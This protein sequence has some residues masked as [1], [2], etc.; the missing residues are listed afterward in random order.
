MTSSS[1]SVSVFVS[2][3]RTALRLRMSR[4]L[5]LASIFLLPLPGQSQTYNDL[6]H[7]LYAAGY[8][9]SVWVNSFD[10]HQS[11]LAHGVF[12]PDVPLSTAGYEARFGMTITGSGTVTTDANGF[13]VGSGTAHNPNP[14]TSDGSVSIDLLSDG[15]LADSVKVPFNCG[16]LANCPW[17]ATFTTR[18]T[19]NHVWTVRVYRHV[20][21]SRCGGELNPDLNGACRAAL[22]SAFHLPAGYQ[23]TSTDLIDTNYASKPG[24]VTTA[25]C[26]AILPICNSVPV[27]TPTSSF[28]WIPPAVYVNTPVT[29]IDTSTGSPTGWNWSFSGGTPTAST[30]Q[31][32]VV[33]FSSAGAK[34]VTLTASNS[35]GRGTTA[36]HT[37][38]VL[39][40]T[41]TG[42]LSASA[43]SPL[44]CQA[45]TLTAGRCST[46]TASPSPGPST[47]AR[48]TPGR[49][50]RATPPASTR[51]RS[52]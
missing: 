3:P 13:F 38:V 39:D 28:S 33:T 41:P 42:T 51:G 25:L 23:F 6:G 1:S 20:E 4:L 47:A 30:L 27:Q 12:N 26:A 7:A 11:Y 48:P 40:P 31:S 10:P 49:A 43:P 16:P 24:A 37:V 44:H 32:P 35:A 9:G 8:S 15:N 2:V 52:S 50:P 14:I 18:R 5:L 17:T 34:T 22:V 46:P 29:F 36:S 21:G 45:V 19:G